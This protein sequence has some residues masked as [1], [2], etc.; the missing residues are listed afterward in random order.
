MNSIVKYALENICPL[1]LNHQKTAWHDQHKVSSLS[2]SDS[3]RS[4]F[5]NCSNILQNVSSLT[6]YLRSASKSI[7]NSWI[8]IFL[9]SASKLKSNFNWYFS[10]VSYLDWE[11]EL[12][13][14]VHSE[15]NLHVLFCVFSQM[16]FVGKFLFQWIIWA[17][18]S[19]LKSIFNLLYVVL[20]TV[21][22]R[23]IEWINE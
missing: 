10:E 20:E 7:A 14:W 5:R 11:F 1:R 4:P 18:C 3:F 23:N 22:I 12:N 2:E 13:D 17:K 15:N 8:N 6:R 9:V 19:R 16:E 21:I